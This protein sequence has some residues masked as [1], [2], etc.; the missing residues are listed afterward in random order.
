LAFF[1]LPASSF[2]SLRGSEDSSSILATSLAVTYVVSEAEM[3]SLRR[4]RRRAIRKLRALSQ[5]TDSKA[6]IFCVDLALEMA[7]LANQAYN[8]GGGLVTLSG[9]A[10][11]D[12]DSL[13]Y[14]LVDQIYDSAHEA[15][16]Y[17]ARHRDSRRIVVIF[18]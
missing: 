8:D 18:R 3:K 9:Y 6:D 7:D 1:F 5:L 14:D 17:I 11:L 12:L 2:S 10:P 4:K 13:G 15:V 16:C